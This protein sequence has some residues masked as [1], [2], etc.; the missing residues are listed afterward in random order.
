MKEKKKEEI[1]LLEGGQCTGEQV[2]RNNEGSAC[3]L[4]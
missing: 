1:G 4:E 3:V 2:E